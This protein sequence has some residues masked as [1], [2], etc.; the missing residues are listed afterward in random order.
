MARKIVPESFTDISLYA[1]V[2]FRA[3]ELMQQGKLTVDWYRD[4]SHKIIVA[5]RRLGAILLFDG[6]KLKSARINYNV[7]QSCAVTHKDM[8]EVE[9]LFLREV[10]YW[11]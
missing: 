8:V 1:W 3:Q 4:N 5:P 2:E 7:H 10:G 11:A 9:D 6:C